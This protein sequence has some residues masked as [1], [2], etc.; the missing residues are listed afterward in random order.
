MRYIKTYEERD[1]IEFCVGDTIYCVD[2][3]W[4]KLGT[5]F[6]VNEIFTYENQDFK[7]KFFKCIKKSQLNC[8]HYLNIKSFDHSNFHHGI[9]ASRFMNEKNYNIFIASNKYNF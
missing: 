9:Y 7:K 3:K 6:V 4:D 1:E 5:K 8:Q 2:E